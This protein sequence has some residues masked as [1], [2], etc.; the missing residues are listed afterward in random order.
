MLCFVHFISYTIVIDRSR[1][2]FVKRCLFIHIYSDKEASDSSKVPVVCLE[3]LKILVSR[4]PPQSHQNT[5]LPSD[6][7]GLKPERRRETPS[8]VSA[9]FLHYLLYIQY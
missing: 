3:R 8:E 9:A 5:D 2:L 7:S 4:H 1:Q 6:T